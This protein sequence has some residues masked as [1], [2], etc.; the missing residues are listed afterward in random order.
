M[1]DNI[2]SKHSSGASGDT[3]WFYVAIGTFAL[4]LIVSVKAY[5]DSTHKKN[6]KKLKNVIK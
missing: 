5:N 2:S 6:Y 4:L 1:E 3:I